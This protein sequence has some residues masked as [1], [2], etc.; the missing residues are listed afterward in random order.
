MNQISKAYD[1]GRP[2]VSDV[3]LTLSAGECMVLVG[4][5]GSGKTTVLRLVAGLETV[6]KGL[7]ISMALTCQ[8]SHLRVAR[9]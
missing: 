2:V 5:S 9:W 8:N 1:T 3:S 6:D 7:C 4:P